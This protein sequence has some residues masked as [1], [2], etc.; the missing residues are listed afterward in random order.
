[1]VTHLCVPYVQCAVHLLHDL[2]VDLAA[3][4]QQ[5][6]HASR[7]D[8]IPDLEAGNGQGLCRGGPVHPVTFKFRFPAVAERPP[9]WHMPHRALR[10]QPDA[11]HIV[12]LG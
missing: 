8:R 2:P 4:H 9:D 3:Q 12:A 10:I 5:L 7:A 6:L 11:S 1:M